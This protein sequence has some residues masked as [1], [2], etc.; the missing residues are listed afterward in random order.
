MGFKN[1]SINLKLSIH[2]TFIFCLFVFVPSSAQE[3]KSELYVIG[4]NTDIDSIKLSKLQ[5][6]FL[7]EE[8]L[9]PNKEGIEIILPSS[10][11]NFAELVSRKIFNSSV[12]G[13]KRYWLGLVFQGRANPPKFLESA[14]DIINYVSKHKGSI[15]VVQCDKKQIPSE[16]YI[17]LLD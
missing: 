11:A 2:I 4:N 15:A 1:S 5:T 7:G 13:M 14:Q 8:A 6:I 3:T 9:W 10:N 17:K 16:L 12:M